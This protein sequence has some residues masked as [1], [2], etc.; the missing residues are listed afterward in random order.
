[1]TLRL[2]VNHVLTEV[3]ANTFLLSKIQ[4]VDAVVC[5]TGTRRA[6]SK[7]WAQ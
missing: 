1:M 3:K 6:P 7:R 2:Q 4:G 5:S